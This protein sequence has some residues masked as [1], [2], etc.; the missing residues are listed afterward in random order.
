MDTVTGARKSVGGLVTQ[1]LG[2]GRIDLGD[3]GGVART[4]PG[5]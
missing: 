2:K 1:C 5:G 3:D 4:T